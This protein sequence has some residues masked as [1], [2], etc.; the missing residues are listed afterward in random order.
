MGDIVNMNDP[1]VQFT[2]S[3]GVV[4]NNSAGQTTTLQAGIYT[5]LAVDP[6]RLM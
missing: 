6:E 4:N 2:W 5:L 1:G 3:G